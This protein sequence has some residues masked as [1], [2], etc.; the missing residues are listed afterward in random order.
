MKQGKSRVARGLASLLALSASGWLQAQ[1][2]AVEELQPIMVQEQEASEADSYQA[3]NSSAATR[4]NLAPKE[5]PQSVSTITRARIDDFQLNSVNDVLENT[6]GVNVEEVETDRTYYT[7]RGFDITNFQFDGVGVPFIYGSQAGDLD[8]ALF[9]RIEVLRGANGLM[10]GIG[11][12]SAT[13]NFV[14]KRPTAE[15]EARVALTAGS[16]DMRRLDTDLS[17]ALTES[18]NVRGRVV[19]ANE[20]KNSYLDRYGREKNVFLGVVEMDLSDTTLFSLGH[21]LQKSDADSPLWGALPTVYSDGSETDYS[22]STNTSSDWAYWN[23]E[24]NRTFAELTQQLGGDWELKGVLTRAELKND[25]RLFYM[26][27]SPVPATGLG[28]FSYPSLYEAKNTQHIADVYASGPFR[29]AGRE[30]ELVVGGSW[31]KSELEDLSHYGQGIGTALPP[32]E[33]WDGNYPMPSF[34]ASVDGS[35]FTDKQKSAYSAV[36]WSLMD[37]LKLITG[38]R[39]IDVDNQ[40]T[41]YGK[42]KSTQYNGKTVPYAGLTYDLSDD[43]TL[44]A[45]YTE[46]FNPQTQLDQ[47]GNRL[48]ALQGENYEV[49]VKASLF[50]SAELTLAMFQTRQDNLAELAGYNGGQAYY[51]ALQGIESQGWEAELAGELLPGLQASA[52]Y[53]FVDITDEQ[54]QH[55]RAYAPKHLLRSSATYRLPQLPK[56]KVGASY[57]WQSQ[58]ENASVEQDAYGLLNL[59]ASYEIDPNWTVAANL[60]NVTDEKY[61]ASLYWDQAYY[62]APRNA[63]MSV[64]W[65]Y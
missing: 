4:L 21:S 14:R 12:P 55:A 44:Y 65:N 59:M 19:Y 43:Y 22:R 51:R 35:E 9:E 50:E 49:G 10:T 41:S 24:E 45:S 3:Q 20:N 16:W 34:D 33:E 63:S 11:N 7:A 42:S 13:V 27:G 46:I 5:T 8:T 28:L 36:R 18:G 47:G 31:S 37:D 60:N 26:Y 17:G 53:T 56:A 23:N 2:Q 38:A 15:T 39:V 54:N 58:T 61:W 62:G 48:E 32:L 29:L 30:H 25:G 6:T 57:N 1:Q 40:G 52:G 64:S